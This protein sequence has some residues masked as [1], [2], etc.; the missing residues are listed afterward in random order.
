[1]PSE[2]VVAKGELPNFGTKSRRR[3]LV[4]TW[5]AGLKIAAP[6]LLYSQLS[7]TV[8]EALNPHLP[9]LLG[10]VSS[11]YLAACTRMLVAASFEA[12][13][14]EMRFQYAD[15]FLLLVHQALLV[16]V[17]CLAKSTFLSPY[18][19]SSCQ[20]MTCA[21]VSFKDP[22][23]Q[24]SAILSSEHYSIISVSLIVLY[25]PVSQEHSESKPPLSFPDCEIVALGALR[26]EVAKS[27][28]ILRKTYPDATKSSHLPSPAAGC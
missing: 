15:Y 19:A 25:W 27:S 20:G 24:L 3:Q 10:Q 2:S 8:G 12:L 7:T 22:P 9:V 11:R 21:I 17:S 18:R 4:K 13:G 28:S 26:Q 6:R 16:T 23:S 1:M 5:G 14:W